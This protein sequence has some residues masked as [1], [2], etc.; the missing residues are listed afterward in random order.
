MRTKIF[1]I[2]H[3]YCT[4]ATLT[5]DAPS[6]PHQPV[7]FSISQAHYSTVECSAPQFSVLLV[8]RWPF[9]HYRTHTYSVYI[10]VASHGEIS[11]RNITAAILAS[12]CSLDLHLEPSGARVALKHQQAAAQLPC[13]CFKAIPASTI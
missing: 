10:T 7:T 2:T 5:P 3:T 11:L 12:D 9:L 1:I 8:V 13:W 6:K 4:M